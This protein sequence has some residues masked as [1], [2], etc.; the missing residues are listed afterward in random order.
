MQ[1][2]DRYLERGVGL[3]AIHVHKAES[4]DAAA[5]HAAEAGFNFDYLH[6]ESQATSK[7]YG[8]TTTPHFFVLDKGRKI[9]YMGAMD[10]NMNPAEVTKH[11]VEEAVNAVLAGT[12]PAVQE[13]R[14]FGCGIKW[15]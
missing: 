13:T 1:F 5:D 7:A 2:A 3:V 10:D 15:K 6:D 12:R 4:F 9:A 14:Q 11:Y 8:A